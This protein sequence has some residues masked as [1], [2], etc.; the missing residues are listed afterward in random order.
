MLLLPTASSSLYLTVSNT[1]AQF[2]DMIQAKMRMTL[3]KRRVAP[4]IYE[5]D[6]SEYFSGVSKSIFPKCFFLISLEYISG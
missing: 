3:L 5:M 4:N 6:F 1:N 2:N